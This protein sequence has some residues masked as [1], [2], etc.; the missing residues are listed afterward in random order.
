M[1]GYPVNGGT[2]QDPDV[3]PGGDPVQWEGSGQGLDQWTFDSRGTCEEAST[4]GRNCLRKGDGPGG[5]GQQ[6]WNCKD[7]NNQPANA[8]PDPTAPR[9]RRWEF[10]G[11]KA[12]RSGA[13]ANDYW[14]GNPWQYSSAMFH[15]WEGG[16]SAYDCEPLYRKFAT[17]V[18][19]YAVFASFSLNAGWT[20]R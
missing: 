10:G 4:R 20:M 13:P 18:E 9:I 17:G 11:R 8:N 19:S 14:N 16:S 3:V 6:P 2:Q 12:A 1:R 7:V 15:A 5:T